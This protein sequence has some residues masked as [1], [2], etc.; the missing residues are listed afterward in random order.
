MPIFEF[1]CN[2]CH[3]VFE[4]IVLNNSTEPIKCKECESEDV[5]K[6]LTACNFKFKDGGRYGGDRG[7]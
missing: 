4:K 5:E 1:K 2:N 3:K 6:C 7:I